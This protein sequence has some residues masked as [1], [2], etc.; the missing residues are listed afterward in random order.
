MSTT[1]V[2]LSSTLQDNALQQKLSKAE[3]PEGVELATVSEQGPRGVKQASLRTLEN[4]QAFL[5]VFGQ[6]YGA[7]QAVEL[8][9]AE[10][11]AIPRA[12]VVSEEALE[13]PLERLLSQLQSTGVL[14]R[15]AR[16]QEDIAQVAE[17]LLLTLSSKALAAN[18]PAA[19]APIQAS[20]AA[21]PLQEPTPTAHSEEE[22]NPFLTSPSMKQVNPFAL[23]DEPADRASA[24][25]LAKAFTA[26]EPSVPA[27]SAPLAP[28]PI[29]ARPPEPVA[30]VVVK[31]APREIPVQAPQIPGRARV[32]QDLIKVLKPKA[33]V[34]LRGI[35]GIGKSVIARAVSQ[36]VAPRFPDGVFWLEVGER[37][38]VSVE[39][40]LA[41]QIGEEIG[42]EHN[43]ATRQELLKGWFHPKQALLVLDDGGD[44][45]LWSLLSLFPEGAILITA[46]ELPRAFAT[47]SL[48][49]IDVPAL[50]S[51]EGEEVT[52]AFWPDIEAQEARDLSKAAGGAPLAIA[53]A[54]ADA[55]AQKVGARQAAA[56]LSAE[57]GDSRIEVAARRALTHLT[58]SHQKVFGASGALPSSS[59]AVGAI[60]NAVDI[61]LETASQLLQE[62]SSRGLMISLGQGRFQLPAAL[63][64]LAKSMP[65]A[66]GAEIRFA[67]FYRDFANSHRDVGREH[68][69]A[70]ENER[71][72]IMIS[73]RSMSER[74]KG[75]PP[76]KKAGW[77][78]SLFGGKKQERDE[79]HEAAEFLVDISSASTTFLNV[80]GYWA[81]WKEICHLGL[82]G[83]V[84][85]ADALREAKLHLEL[86][87]L[88]RL[89]HNFKESRT[90]LTEAIGKFEA[91]NDKP[92]K[93]QAQHNLALLT[94]EEKKPKEALDLLNQAIQN[95]D[96]ATSR[97]WQRLK[98]EIEGAIKAGK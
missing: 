79:R 92:M 89:E 53:I 88:L 90:H 26:P 86:G 24:D 5:G 61:N 41:W 33:R 31:E 38:L 37:G 30:P 1:R 51:D 96:Q 18:Q 46:K 87:S 94:W 76:K 10:E 72:G 78:S 59:F 82:E 62:L 84:E 29:E 9:R 42:T 27:E 56:A 20:P 43:R 77:L 83:A 35:D 32:L 52:K 67:P 73:A 63:R 93:A 68:L 54:V 2:F 21:Q 98:N 80:R 70:M 74:L 36:A 44:K 7:A 22:Q 60:A 47:E 14:V 81:E 19:Q 48:Q 25:E 95:A 28:P 49:I 57:K 40:R 6:K 69:N 58:E 8:R 17:E 34:L 45:E 66:Q 11:K 15:R 50:T 85:L 4:C 13:K 97:T 65:G 23:T 75:L 16:S 39:N 64:L 55:K 3:L 12:I 91:A 71:E